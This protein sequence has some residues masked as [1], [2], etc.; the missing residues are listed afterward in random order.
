ML[1]GSFAPRVFRGMILLLCFPCLAGAGL[2]ELGTPFQDHAILQRNRPIVIWG[3]AREGVDIVVTLGTAS[4][5]VR[6]DRD[7]RWRLTLP[8]LSAGGPHILAISDG[9]TTL[10]KKDVLIGDVWL[11]S[12]QSNMAWTVE[13]SANAAAEMAAAHY[14]EIRFLTVPRTPAAQLQHAVG[15]S[16]EQCSPATVGACSAV[17]YYFAR[18]QWQKHRVPVGLIVAPVGGSTIQPWISRDATSDPALAGIADKYKLW[19]DDLEKRDEEFRRRYRDWVKD[20]FRADEHNSGEDGGWA[21]GEFDDEGWLPLTMPDFIE[22]QSITI[23]GVF[24]LRK[25]V[26]IP[27]SWAGR[28]LVLDLGRLDDCDITYFNGQKVGEVTLREAIVP[29]LVPRI[30][31]IPGSLVKAGQAI[32][33]VRVSDFT[34]SGGMNP[35]T[36]RLDLRLA[37]TP[38]PALE[39]RGVWKYAVEQEVKGPL[40]PAPVRDQETSLFFNG[41]ISPFVRYGLRGFLWYQGESNSDDPLAYCELFPLLI[42]DWRRHWEDSSLPFLFV[43][44]AGFDPRKLRTLN[45]PNAYT[46]WVYLREAQ[47]FALTVPY[48]EMVSAIDLGDPQNIHPPN[49]QEVGRRLSLCAD[50]VAHG[51]DIACSGPRFRKAE[52]EGPMVRVEFANVDGGLKAEGNIE[53]FALA[54]ED[55]KFHWASAVI[56]GSEVEVYCPQVPK[57]VSI[58]YAW[59]DDP[60]RANLRDAAGLPAEPFRLDQWDPY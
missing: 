44:L 24:W 60:S 12:G 1:G 15:G 4:A 10:E 35:E 34:G 7:G 20:Y 39:L 2:L 29:S 3:T 36:K 43:Q 18:D 59:Q 13:Q 55:R 26:L 31:K 45:D 58:R 25:E 47:S 52:I 33:A 28:D 41:M 37:D 14:P 40:P 42:K 53:G 48:T 9:S 46:Y 27:A 56:R 19:P 38:E 49:K 11:C 30:Y 22:R 23:N 54:G 21:K 8:A 50:R 16:W 6:C 57:P 32:V 17:A 5:H 51:E